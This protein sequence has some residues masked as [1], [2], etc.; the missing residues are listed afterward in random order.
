MLFKGRT[1]TLIA[2]LALT[3]GIGAN[4]AIFSVVNAVLLKPLP[5]PHP[6]RL[7]RV[8]EKSQQFEQMSVSYPNFRDWQQQ[9][10]S[11]EQL[12][13]FRYQGF[14]ITGTQGP[15]RVQGRMISSSFFSVLGVQPAWGR[16]IAPDEDRLG[17]QPV[18]ILSYA[19][20]QRRFGGDPEMVGK[21]IIINGKSHTIIGILPASFRFY[22]PSDLF[23]ALGSQDDP[24]FQTRDVHPGLRAIGRLKPNVTFEQARGEME[25]IALGLEK[26]Y[27]ASNTGYSVTMVTMYDDMVGD[28]RPALLVL[29]GAVGFVLLIAC[30]NVANLLLARAAGRQKEIAIRTAL[31]ASRVRI[32]RQL[33]TESIMLGMVGGGLGLLLAL[34]GTE[35][36]VAFIPDVLPRT[37][38]IG[39]DGGVLTFTLAMSLATGVIFGLVPAMQASKPDLNESLKEG[40]RT[41]QSG[42]HRARG[43]LV[44]VEVALALVLL[45]GAGLMIRS[46][47]G[48]RGVAPGINAKNVLTMSIPLSQSTYNEPAKIRMFYEQLLERLKG[49]PGVQRA[50]VNADMPLTGEDSEVPFWVS[51][52]PRPAPEDMPFGLIYPISAG[53]AEAM[54]LPLL[55][56]RFLSEQDTEKSPSVAVIDENMARELF[57][58]Q[59]P[60]GQRLTIR[61]IGPMPEWPMEIVGVVGHVKHFGLDSD[62]KQKIQ[63]QFYFP[64][65]QV[66]DI[67]LPQM[68]ENLTL[69]TRTTGDPVGL[70]SAI[71]DQVLAVDKDQPVS[72]VRTMEQ[73]VSDSIAQQR[74]SMLLLGL[75]AAVALVLAGVGIYGVMSYSVAQR[76]HEMGIRMALGARATD[77]LGMVVKQGMMLAALGVVIGLAAAFLLTRLMAS[78]LYG[79]SAT[80]PLTFIAISL[81]LA[82]V[83][84]G[85]CFIPARRATKVDPMVA[86]RYE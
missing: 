76:T 12:A 15:E 31:G 26:Q 42:R 20:W 25:N 70:T 37:E 49:V 10:Q 75:F 82:G 78:L 1:V 8:Y 66:P 50:A 77:V 52:G 59:D 58:N 60:I 4:T 3:L 63:Y 54:G 18:T 2:V 61:G 17:G 5:Y 23:V 13:A 84:L 29:L 51:T 36:L 48:L 79:V 71:K 83:A 19:F 65:R 35:A 22:S 16:D 81:L 44:V 27:P 34:W 30:A 46:I 80:D 41:S 6:E 14:N 53:Y 47:Y 24:L 9:N 45:I 55:K 72:N 56:G 62:A 28:I 21:P 85:A 74:F 68:A 38:D 86:L 67:F 43:V 69:V 39:I 33:L 32:V 73:I 7:V 64:Y 40:G 57:P 11:F